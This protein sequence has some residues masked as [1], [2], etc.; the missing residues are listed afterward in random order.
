MASISQIRK[1]L[2][3]AKQ[4][5]SGWAVQYTADVSELI[6]VAEAARFVIIELRSELLLSDRHANKLPTAMSAIEWASEV[7]DQ[8]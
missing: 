1:T 8:Y 3:V 7:L 5:K 6:G 2:E 4:G